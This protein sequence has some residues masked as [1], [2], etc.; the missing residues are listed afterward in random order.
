MNKTVRRK[1]RSET[2][3]TI[4]ELLIAALIALAVSVAAF[5]FF[6]AQH[7]LYLAQI[8]IVE[9]QGNLRFAISD[10]ALQVR[11]AGYLVKGGDQLRVASNF[12]TL[13]VYGGNDTS[14]SIDTLRYYVNHYDDPPTLVRQLNHQTPSVFAMG[15]DSAFFVPAGGVPP[16][17]IAVSLV[18]VEQAQYEN[19]ALTTRR[20]VAETINLRN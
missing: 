18:S 1:L 9:R 11:R 20:R 4:V 16:A 15:V 13:E 5:E 6:Q 12:D 17:R 14:L 10:L 19:T 3:I 7:E 8:D 2:G